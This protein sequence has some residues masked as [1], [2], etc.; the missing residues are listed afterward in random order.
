MYIFHQVEQHG[1]IG[2][3]RAHGETLAGKDDQTDV[4]V[5]TTRNELGSHVFGGFDPVGGTV[6]GQPTAR[7]I[8]RQ[9]EVDPFGR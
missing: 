4:V 9:Y 5:L 2:S 1:V 6:A 3:H 7:N 8:E